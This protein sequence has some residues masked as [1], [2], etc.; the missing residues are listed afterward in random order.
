MAG[1]TPILELVNVVKD[2]HD[3]EVPLRVL[4]GVSLKVNRGD[5]VSVMGFSG[6]GKSTLLHIIGCLDKP[7]TGRVMVNGVDAS[8]LSSDRLAD[9]RAST[10]GFV[11]QS[12]NLLPNLSALQTVELAMAIT[13]TAGV[14]RRSRALELL[15]AVGLQ[16]RV[17]HKP[18]EMSGGEKQRVAIARAL[19]NKPALLL[20]D[21]P[22]GNLDTTSGT[23]VMDVVEKLW[24]EQGVTV[25]VITHEKQIAAYAQRVVHIK[26][27]RIESASG[28]AKATKIRGVLKWK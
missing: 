22:T 28:A 9:L 24:K 5:F 13:E 21:E 23:E 16:Q 14:E 15:K 2:Y 17:S 25:L 18:A 7:T 26:D 11:F 20:M 6:S 4:H 1:Q 12:F 8:S 19:A 10:I 3:G 27:G